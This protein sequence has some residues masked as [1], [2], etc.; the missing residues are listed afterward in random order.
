[1]RKWGVALAGLA[2]AALVAL[3]V[4]GNLD[5]PL[6]SVGL[7]FHECARNGLGA[8]FCGSELDAYRAR[9]QRVQESVARIKREGEETQQHIAQHAEERARN[10][11]HEWKA[12]CANDTN[13]IEREAACKTWER[14][15]SEAANEA[16]G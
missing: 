15:T 13:P 1:M 5:R 14:L 8:T 4:H 12:Q 2:V 9:V 16:G 3:Y 7:N 10:E 11:R 6:Y